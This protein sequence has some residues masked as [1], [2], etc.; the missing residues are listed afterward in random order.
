MTAGVAAASPVAGPAPA[1]A[2]TSSNAA[3]P[4]IGREERAN[5]PGGDTLESEVRAG[6]NTCCG[7]GGP[8]TAAAAA[9]LWGGMGGLR[10][11][12]GIRA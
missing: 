11:A 10:V 9:V 1:R 4:V 7:I 6:I 3:V 2:M 8:P 12:R 5:Q